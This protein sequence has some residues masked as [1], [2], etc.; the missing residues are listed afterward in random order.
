MRLNSQAIL[1]G[2]YAALKVHIKRNGALEMLSGNAF[3][4]KA[5]YGAF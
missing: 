3:L 4:G 2:T 5:I 1:E